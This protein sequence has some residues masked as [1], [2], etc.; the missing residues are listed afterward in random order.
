MEEIADRVW[1]LHHAW[2]E[3]NVTVVAGTGGAVVVDTHASATAARTL[4]EDVRRVLGPLPVV[5]VVNTHEH[6]DHCFGNATV[7]EHTGKV[8]VHAHEVAAART[9]ESGN[10]VKERYRQDPDDP[11][12]EEVLATDIRP[13]DTT[14]S[15]RAAIDLGGRVVEL[16]YH[17]RGH[18]GGDAVIVVPDAGVLVAGDLVEES[19]PP[20]LGG[21]SYPLEWPAT[22]ARVL[23]GA[24][25]GTVV[26][27]GHGA[28]VDVGF[29][30]AQHEELTLVADTIRRL[31]ADGVPVEQAVAAGRWPWPDAYV[32]DAVRRGY[33]NVGENRTPGA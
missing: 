31:V 26:V 30:R 20:A 4:V 1:V 23:A 28:V 29:A 11:H 14:F 18:T 22:L 21:D 25:V 9:V 5:G 17:G 7:L 15:T 16:L 3:L 13:A 6:F 2:F 33:A 10:R 32:H 12:R 24:S 27:P 8:P 19:A